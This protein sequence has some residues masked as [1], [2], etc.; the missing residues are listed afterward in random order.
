MAASLLMCEVVASRASHGRAASG[1]IRR[2]MEGHILDKVVRSMRKSTNQRAGRAP[3]GRV[4]IRCVYAC[5][6][7]GDVVGIFALVTDADKDSF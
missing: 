7:P 1:Q 6:V 5:D 4:L 2:S 3:A